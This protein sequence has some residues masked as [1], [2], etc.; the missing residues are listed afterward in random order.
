MNLAWF[1]IPILSRRRFPYV[2]IAL[3][4]LFAAPVFGHGV[5]L[6]D[7]WTN[8]LLLGDLPH[9]QSLEESGFGFEVLY[10]GEVFS[11]LRG[12][13]NTHDAVEWRD[14]WSLF[15]EFDTE[16]A[17]WWEGGLFLLHLQSQSGNGIT[18]RHVGDFQV[19]SNIDADDYSQVSEFW[20]Q[21]ISPGGGAWV[22]FG[23]MEANT[24]FAYVDFGCEFINSSAGFA[25]TIP[26]TTYPDQDWGVTVGLEPL[27][28]FSVNLGVYQ[29]EPDGGRALGTTLDELENP[30]YMVEPSL[31]Y[32]CCGLDGA[33]R[34]GWWHNETPGEEFDGD[35]FDDMSGWYLTLDQWFC[36]ENPSDEEDDQGIGFFAQYGLCTQGKVAGTPVLRRR[37]SLY[38]TCPGAGC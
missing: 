30:M 36:K 23:K 33:M 15:L 20:Y 3:F 13:L 28:W 12:G 19:L 14:D 1:S 37:Y 34:F 22:K 16:S 35:L 18:D 10:T 8:D 32:S 21:H 9:R 5:S 2:P 29:G 31:H 38:G 7:F 24:D 6:N 11:N 17:G 25:P 27:E 26:L 4:F